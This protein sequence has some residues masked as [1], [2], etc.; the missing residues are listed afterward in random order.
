MTGPAP[1]QH[2]LRFWPE[3]GRLLTDPLYWPPSQTHGQE[4]VR[5]PALLIPGFLAGDASLT[6]LAG[7]L[8]RRGH[9]VRTSGIRLNVGCSGR[10][11]ER[12]DTVLEAFGEPVVLIGQSRGGILARALAARHPDAVAA[13]VTLGAP[14]LDPLAVS[15]HVL[16]TVR[17]VAF[18]GDLGVRGLFST[19][20]RDGACCSEF[21]SLLRKPLSPGAPALAVYSR[22][23]AIVDWHACLDPHAES[24]EIDGSHCGMA[25]NAQVY[26]ELERVLAR[27]EQG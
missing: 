5:R 4:R 26:C 23:D 20:C 7:W 2:E 14:V 3:L 22:T 1:L 24:F 13:L 27:S 25:V 10:D 8:R 11:L 16:R 12:L 19:E 6:V 15:P 17:S 18:L 9:A 21:R